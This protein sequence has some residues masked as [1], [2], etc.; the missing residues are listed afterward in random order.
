MDV[1]SMEFDPM[2]Y[3]ESLFVALSCPV[4][5]LERECRVEDNDSVSVICEL[6]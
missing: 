5:Q 6:L 2:L 3:N 4:A 1:F